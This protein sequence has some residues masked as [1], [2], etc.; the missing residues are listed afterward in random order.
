MNPSLIRRFEEAPKLWLGPRMLDAFH[1]WAAERRFRPGLVL[2]ILAG[3]LLVH[4]QADSITELPPFVVSGAG[5]AGA[6]PP[7]GRPGG[8]LPD[9]VSMRTRPLDERLVDGDPRA[10]L[11]RRSGS[12]AAHPTAQGFTLGGWAPSGTSRTLVLRDG[13]PLNDPFGGWIPWQGVILDDAS[14]VTV[15]PGGGGGLWGIGVGGM[16]SVVR[17]E[18]PRTEGGLRLEGR[19]RE[20]GNAA[21][22]QTWAEGRGFAGVA[23]QLRSEG[24]YRVVTP[25]QAGP[26]DVPVSAESNALRLRLGRSPAEEGWGGGL[27]LTRF[28]ED[29]VNGTPLSTNATGITEAVLRLASPGGGDR[30]WRAI[31]FYREGSFRNQFTAVA[32]DRGSERPALEQFAVPSRTWGGAVT[33]AAE[34]DS[35]I[36]FSAGGDA[37]RT[38]AATNERYRNLGAGFTRARH[39]GGIDRRGGGFLGLAWETPRVRY[40]VVVRL[41]A[42][43]IEE[44]VRREISLEDGSVLRDERFPADGVVFLSGRLSGELQLRDAG[45]LQGTVWRGVRHPNLNERFRPFRVG[46]DITEANPFLSSETAHGVEVAWRFGR[47]EWSGSLAVRHVRVE[48]PVANVV[49]APG[50]GVIDPCGFVPP[51]GSCGQ[52]LNLDAVETTG[53]DAGLDWSPTEEFRIRVRASVNRNRIEDPG[54]PDLDGRRPAQSPDWRAVAGLD[55]EPLPAHHWQLGVVAEGRRFE[56]NGNT[57]Q[58]DGL[59]VGEVSYRWSPHDAFALWVGVANLGDAVIETGRRADGLLNIGAPRT[60]RAGLEWRW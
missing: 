17:P 57:R 40:S 20:R 25:E 1:K 18:S 21:L 19:E 33:V 53:V 55:W 16:L 32:D 28:S 22:H 31:G 51:G 52:R 15:D 34:T 36:R 48:D 39:A 7:E 3:P 46:N 50:P 30:R 38:D 11:F 60:Y 42:N 44:A 47:D 13:M 23:A 41:D 37:M 29:R 54:R 12:A 35:G 2:A 6:L 59:V 8:N 4:A 24:G 26:V 49:L 58:L 5:A 27:E 56:D 43:R 45:W 9:S 10:G 14:E